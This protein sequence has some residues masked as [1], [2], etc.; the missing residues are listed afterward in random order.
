MGSFALVLFFAATGLTLNHPD[1]FA[2]QTKTVQLH[3]QA[4]VALLH[5]RDA[6]GANKLALVELLRQHDHVRG[7]VSDL[8]VDDTQISIS[9]RAPGYTADAFIDRDTGKYD[10]TQVQNGFVAVMNDLHRGRDAGR[11]WGLLIDSSSVL[12]I[13]VSITG[14]VLIWFVYKRRTSGLLLAGIAALGLI[15]IVRLHFL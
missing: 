8:R 10:I 11:T 12:L 5:T 13:A 15:V 9:F 3:G 2:G 14:L 1:W 7:A 6:D 4:P